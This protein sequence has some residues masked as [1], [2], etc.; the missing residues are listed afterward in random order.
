[1]T[2]QPAW[3][4]TAIDYLANAWRLLQQL[5]EAI[6]A[7]WIIWPTAAL[8]VTI[9]LRIFKATLS[10]IFRSRREDAGKVRNLLANFFRS[11][12]SL[13][14]FI[15]SLVVTAPFFVTLTEDQQA[16]LDGAL[17]V[18]LILQAA[19][20]VRVI[21]RAI[22]EEV[23][24]RQAQDSVTFKSA[25]NLIAVFLNIA[26][27]ALAAVM[28]IDNLGGDVTAL[29]AGLGVGGIAVGL[30]AQNIFKDL[31]ASL[32]IILDKPFVKGDF[33][34]FG[35]F[36][37]M[38]D[39]IGMKTT[40]IT[41][42]SGEQLVVGN[43]EL[44]S[45]TLRNYNRLKER[46]VVLNFSVTYQ[47]SRHLLAGLPRQIKQIVETTEGCRFDRCHVATYGATSIDLE[48]V[49]YV[50]SASFVD[51]M[52]VKQNIYLS[53]HEMFE[54]NHIDFAYPTQTLFIQNPEAKE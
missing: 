53:V 41:A 19:F 43:D 1:M 28:V 24:A 31:F 20:W 9:G 33:I 38:I 14:L 54:K 48:L 26:I 16:W 10:G 45:H 4:T 37:G 47:I 3:V 7:D 17:M 44:L 18:A 51:H 34:K 36:M 13:F 29:L 21:V 22:M 40:Q 30:A 35:D 15:V 49:Y 42:L 32:S 11:T 27:F 6:G 39:R 2:Q 8:L 25:R 5:S 12:N 52:N 23:V 46:R 50:L